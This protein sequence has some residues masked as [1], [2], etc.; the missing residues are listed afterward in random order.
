MD[1]QRASTCERLSVAGA[2]VRM[3]PS[4]HKIDD[5]LARTHARLRLWRAMRAMQCYPRP[6]EVVC[7]QG[8][9]A[10]MRSHGT[11]LRVSQPT[12]VAMG[13]GNQAPE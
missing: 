13:G 10:G 12:A 6:R 8:E 9:R 4:G 3:N 2:Q 7:Q 5:G 11:K 1:S